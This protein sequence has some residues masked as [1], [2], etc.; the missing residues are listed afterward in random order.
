MSM[1]AAKIDLADAARRLTAA[2]VGLR[3]RR[4]FRRMPIVVSGRML[5]PPAA[6]T[7]AAPP[8]SRRATSAS[9]PPTLPTDRRARRAL[10]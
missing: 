2:Q 1:H 9:P 6:N 10:S 8:T 4:R 3:E 5:D 7:I